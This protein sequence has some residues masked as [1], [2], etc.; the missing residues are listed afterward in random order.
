VLVSVAFLIVVGT[1]AGY[2]AIIKNQAAGG[3]RPPD[4]LTPVFVAGCLGAMAVLLALALAQAS[5]M[6][7]VRPALLAAASTG[8]L[9][10][11]VLGL[12]SVGVPI[13][14]AAVL[15]ITATAMT[16]STRRTRGAVLSA[17]AAAV[18][19]LAL[20]VGGL[21]F[22][23]GYLVCPKTGQSGGTTAGFFTGR[24]YECNNGQL[25]FTGS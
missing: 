1:D 7:N 3:D 19:A 6:L 8:L 11:G 22:S 18:V 17:L 16:I 25:T 13:L 2:I 23:W 15:S 21:E 12:F 20:L 4:V 14:I 10:L 24:S 9:V 5:P